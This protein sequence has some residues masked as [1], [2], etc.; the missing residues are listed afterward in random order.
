MVRGDVSRRQGPAHTSPT[1]M[2]F[3]E[4]L[5]PLQQ[6]SGSLKQKE[7]TGTTLHRGMTQPHFATTTGAQS[8]LVITN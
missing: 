1:G 7:G 3:L 4:R 2:R 5:G 8:C 6:H